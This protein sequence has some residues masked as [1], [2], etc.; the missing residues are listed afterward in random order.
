[1]IPESLI[2]NLLAKEGYQTKYINK[3]MRIYHVDVENSLSS[4]A[5]ENRAFGSAIHSIA[6]F[7]WFFKSYFFTAPRFFLK[8]AYVLLRASKYLPC[9]LY[10]LL[11]SVDS[12]LVKIMLIILG[13]FRKLTI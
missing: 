13:P 6:M 10:E 4:T 5:I 2:W 7:N 1:M 8:R 9:T 12:N 3:V 11:R